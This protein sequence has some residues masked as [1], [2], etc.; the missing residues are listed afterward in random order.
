M[1]DFSPAVSL[2]GLATPLAYQFVFVNGRLLLPLDEQAPFDPLPNRL[3]NANPETAHYLGRLDGHDC[4]AVTLDVEPMGWRSVALRAA[5]MGFPH[6]VRGVAA[7]AA[8]IVEWDRA[9]RFCGVCGTAT[10]RK[11]DERV[12]VCPSCS[13]SA[14]PRISPAMMALVWREGEVLLGRSPHFAPGFY[15]A[16]AGFVEP[17]ESIEDC[18]RREV[19]EE[20]GVQ[21]GELHYFGSQNWPFPHSLMLAFTARWESGEIVPQPGE[22]EHAAWFKLDA[23]PQIS[24]RFSISGHLIRDTVAALMQGDLNLTTFDPYRR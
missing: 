21:V 9:H 13:H 10:E 24:P 2:A 23:L 15:S 8:Q 7:R 1:V 14:Y 4:W 3:F 19:M 22:I 18:V 6:D 5:M 12:R 11:P 20:V 17:G 16:L